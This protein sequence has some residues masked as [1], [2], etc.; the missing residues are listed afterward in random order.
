MNPIDKFIDTAYEFLNENPTPIE[1]RDFL[2]REATALI[3]GGYKLGQE[4]EAIAHQSEDVNAVELF[5]QTLKQRVGE[6]KEYNLPRNKQKHVCEITDHNIV[7]DGN[8]YTCDNCG[9][10]FRVVAQIKS[11]IERIIDSLT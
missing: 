11:D 10:E 4:D 7:W 9:W 1:I 5:K 3:E 8:F 6:I 2:K